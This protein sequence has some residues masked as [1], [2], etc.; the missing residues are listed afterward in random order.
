VGGIAFAL[1]M[2]RHV[3]ETEAFGIAIY[4]AICNIALLWLCVLVSIDV[5][6]Q[7]AFVRFARKIPCILTWDDTGMRAETVSL[8][9]GDA[10][11]RTDGIIPSFGENTFMHLLDLDLAVDLKEVGEA[12]QMTFAFRD[13]TLPQRRVLIEHLFC[14]PRQ[15]DRPPR[16]ELRAAWEYMRAGLRMYPLAESA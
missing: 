16:S 14:Q 9:E 15:W 4:F 5:A 2:Q 10:V 6:Q 13:L 7:H 11:V 1:W 3:E 8:S 12:G